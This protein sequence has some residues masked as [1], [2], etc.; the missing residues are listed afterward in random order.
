[1]REIYEQYHGKEV[2]TMWEVWTT[3]INDAIEEYKQNCGSEE[4]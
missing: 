3:D 1:M 4:E 2:T